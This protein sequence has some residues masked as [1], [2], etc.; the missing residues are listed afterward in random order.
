MFDKLLKMIFKF[1]LNERR[2]TI[3]IAA[4]LYWIV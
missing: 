2:E 4:K 3:F 1:V